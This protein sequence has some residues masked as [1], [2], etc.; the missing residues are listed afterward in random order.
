M[1]FTKAVRE[2]ENCVVGVVQ[3]FHFDNQHIPNIV[4]TG[5]FVSEHGIVATCRHVVEACL[6]LPVPQGYDRKHHGEPLAVICFRESEVNGKKKWGWFALDVIDLGQATFEGD[7]P[8]Y[9]EDQDPDVAFLFLNVRGTPTVRFADN[10]PEIGEP[11]AFLG[12]PMGI[13]TLLGHQGLRQESPTLHAGVVAAINPNRVSE[14]PYHFLVHANTQGGASGSPVFREDASVV[15]MLF[16]GIP[17]YYYGDPDNPRNTAYEVPTA[18]SGCIYGPLLAQSVRRVQ[19]KAATM[20][21]RPLLA[22]KFKKVIV[23]NLKPDEHV[24]EP[25]VPHDQRNDA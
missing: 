22:E 24:M 13:R 7:K 10:P 21:D 20:S 4:G 19:V 9:V 23:H 25:F 17:E 8:H 15:G 6:S 11:V 12:Y 18:L 1:N 14:S 2:M 3:K 5:F 16:M